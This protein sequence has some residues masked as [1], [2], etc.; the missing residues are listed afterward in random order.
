MPII[1]KCLII[2]KYSSPLRYIFLSWGSYMPPIPACGRQSQPGIWIQGQPGLQTKLQD[3]NYAKKSHVM[4]S[5]TN[6]NK[7]NIFLWTVTWL[8]VVKAHAWDPCGKRKL[9]STTYPLM[10]ICIYFICT[11]WYMKCIHPDTDI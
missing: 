9:I 2:F 1:T 10:S 6:Q 8:R 3:K 5:Y 7:R 11:H 4:K